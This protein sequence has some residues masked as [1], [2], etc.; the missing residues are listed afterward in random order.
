MDPNTYEIK[1]KCMIRPLKGDFSSMA[2]DGIQWTEDIGV[3][4][5]YMRESNEVMLRKCFELDWENMKDVAKKFKKSD[6]RDIKDE[7]WKIY[8]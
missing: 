3:F 7:M 4:K 5:R 2:D 6:E 8:P 1:T